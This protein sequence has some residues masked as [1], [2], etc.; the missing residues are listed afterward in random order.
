MVDYVLEPRQSFFYN[1]Y[2]DQISI[3][4]TE[5]LYNKLVKMNKL[6]ES[7]ADSL[8]HEHIHKW[9]DENIGSVECALFDAIGY[10]FRNHKLMLRTYGQQKDF[11]CWKTF[12]DREGFNAFTK[13]YGLSHADLVRAGVKNE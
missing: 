9:I 12:I 1:E 6:S 13:W 5:E 11:E 7:I 8:T 3:G 4:M 10:L 2:L